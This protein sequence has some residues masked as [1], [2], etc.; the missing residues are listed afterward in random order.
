M[1]FFVVFYDRKINFRN[2]RENEREKE[3]KSKFI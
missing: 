3:I 2:G 1:I